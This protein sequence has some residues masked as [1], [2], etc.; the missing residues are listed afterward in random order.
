MMK[1]IGAVLF[2]LI[3]AVFFVNCGGG[4]KKEDVKPVVKLVAVDFV[5]TSDATQTAG[6]AVATAG[7]KAAETVV[8]NV[9]AVDAK[10]VWFDGDLTVAWKADA[11]LEVTPATGKVVTVKA[12]KA[13]TAA[14]K[15][16]ATATINGKALSKVF[17][18]TKPVAAKPAPAKK[19]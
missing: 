9:K 8:V 2:T 18:V 10:G 3:A 5:V 11:N 15:V 19:K 12:K 16:T 6:P 4:Q 7:L 17:T 1:K 13:I 14:Q